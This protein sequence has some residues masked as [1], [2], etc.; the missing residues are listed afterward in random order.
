[1]RVRMIDEG[2]ERR[3]GAR[4]A[5]L[6]QMGQLTVSS[7]RDGVMHTISLTGELDLATV[8]EAEHE[9][10]RVESTDAPSIVLDLSGLTFID[11]TGVRLLVSAHARSRADSHRLVLLRGPAS[12][13]RVFELCGIQGLL[14]FAD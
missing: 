6:L 11:S 4:A 7:E 2:S 12:V 1:M 5:D 14:P 9:L 8:A 10:L 13:Q 3:G